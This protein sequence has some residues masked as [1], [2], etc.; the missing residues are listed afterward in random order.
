MDTA[1]SQDPVCHPAVMRGTYEGKVSADGASIGGTWTQG[2]L[3]PLELRRG[4]KETAWQIDPTPHRAQF[5]TV[6]KDVKLEVLDWG[7]LRPAGGSIGGPR[8]RRSCIR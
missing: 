5:I 8:K 1:K 4:T 6:D 2:A 7:W 3:L